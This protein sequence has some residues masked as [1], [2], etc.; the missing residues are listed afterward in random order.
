MANFDDL[1]YLSDTDLRS[2]IQEVRNNPPANWD[3]CKIYDTPRSYEANQILG[4]RKTFGFVPLALQ[5]LLDALVSPDC[6]DAEL[7]AVLAHL[8]GS[9]D[10]IPAIIAARAALAK[11]GEA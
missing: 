6:T 3:P 8:A 11:A 1:P 4:R 2:I 7:P 10:I 9:G 5:G